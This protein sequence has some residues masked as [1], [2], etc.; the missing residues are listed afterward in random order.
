MGVVA[1]DLP[2]KTGEVAVVLIAGA[3]AVGLGSLL[4]VRASRGGTRLKV[5][6]GVVV[7]AAILAAVA[8]QVSSLTLL[9]VLVVGRG[10]LLGYGQT[11]Q[12]ALLFDVVPPEARVRALARWRGAAVFGAAV[13]AGL[14]AG[15]LSGPEWP[16]R[17]VLTGIAVATALLGLALA[18]VDDP[19]SAASSCRGCARSPATPRRPRRSTRWAASLGRAARTAGARVS[20]TGFAG[21]GFAGLGSVAATVVALQDKDLTIGSALLGLTA[22][23]A[24]AALVVVLAADGLEARR[25]A[26]PARL[27]MAVPVLLGIAAIGIALAASLPSAAGALAAAGVVAAATGLAAAC[28]DVTAMSSAEPADRAAVAALATCSVLGG[29]VLAVFWINFAANRFDGFVAFATLSLAVAACAAAST[30]LPKAAATSFQERLDGLAFRLEALHGDDEAARAER[31]GDPRLAARPAA[32]GRAAA[33]LAADRG[34]AGR[35]DA[36]ARSAVDPGAPDAGAVGRP[37]P[38]QRAVRGGRRRRPGRAPRRAGRHPD[39]LRPR[40]NAAEPPPRPPLAPLPRRAAVGAAGLDPAGGLRPAHRPDRAGA[41]HRVAG[42]RHD[43][44]RR[45]AAPR[46]AAVP[47]RPRAGR[48]PQRPRRGA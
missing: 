10:I 3:L 27:A 19:G 15:V 38:A 44:A 21:V 46:R 40:A 1:A 5:L 6:V 36:P 11:L 48:A 33:D 14:A 4:A 34:L 47:E 13:A 26:D 28:L 22:A 16:W 43:P 41:R 2:A 25:R 35:P 7:N 17:A 23:W 39:R 37:R 30:R 24:A 45:A 8:A 29:A 31:V 18:F 12:R 9:A 32:A 42:R 20:G